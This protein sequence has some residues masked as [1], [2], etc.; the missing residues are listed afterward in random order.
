VVVGASAGGVEALSVLVGSLPADLPAPVVVAQHLDP[1]RPSHL[2]EILAR[3]SALPVRTVDDHEALVPGTV[4]VVPANRHVEITDHAVRLRVRADAAR[5][6]APSVDLLL[7][8]AEAFG[9]GLV[10][11]S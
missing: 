6:P 9:E 2:G 5:R 4:Y 1:A 7:A 3:R 8:T 11:V 10:A